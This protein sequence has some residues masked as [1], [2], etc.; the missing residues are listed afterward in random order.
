MAGIVFAKLSRPKRRA[1]TILFSKNAV[2]SKTNGVLRLMYRVA[3][4]RHSQLFES[5]FKGIILAK[6]TTDEGLLI[7]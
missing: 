6:I 4:V 7:K 2:I 1:T 3:N 5:H